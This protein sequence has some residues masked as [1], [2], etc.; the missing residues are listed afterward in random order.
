MNFG[1]FIKEKR[2]NQKLSIREVSRISGVSHPYISQIENGK[3]D[4]P[5]P[6]ILKKLA[7]AFENVTYIGLLRAAGYSDIA[8]REKL[9]DIFGAEHDFLEQFERLQVL[10]QIVDLKVFLELDFLDLL[11]NPI[12]PYYN[13]HLL[14]EQDRQR[15]LDVLKVLFPEYQEKGNN[16]KDANNVEKGGA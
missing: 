15:I 7:T 2:E 14:T 3:I 10:E 11:F 12:Y 4:K 9:T 1:E 8:N 6:N 5:S 16:L 13:G